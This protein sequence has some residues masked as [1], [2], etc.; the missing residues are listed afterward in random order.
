MMA[1]LICTF[2]IIWNSTQTILRLRAKYKGQDVLGGP[3]GLTPE[4][5]IVFENLGNGVFQDA[6]EAWGFS[7]RKPAF[8]LNATI[9]DFT[10]DGLQDVFVGNDSMANNLFVNTG[11]TPT[12]FEDKG[13]HTGVAANGDGS[14]QATMGIAIADVN[15][16]KR[17]D[18]FTT[19]FSSDTN[20]LHTN[21]AS[22]YFD[23]RTKRFGLG[24]MSRLH[25][26]WSCGFH[27]F[28]LDGDEDL[29][30]V[31]GHVYPEASLDTM[32]SP[33]EQTVLLVERVGDRFIQIEQKQAYRDRS[34]VFGDLDTDGDIDIIVG[35]RG[36]DIRVLRNDTNIS[37]PRYSSN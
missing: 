29:F 28:D 6:T 15:G 19:N 22:G 32:D 18:V 30:I 13:L 31:N 9:L 11:E 26:G 20:T 35:Q 34:A 25:L 17:P 24:I 16:N 2:V 4:K 33:R 10:G 37:N 7:Q 8:S 23:D 14:M 27:D 36:G 5:D 1:I 3:H 21:D 12:R